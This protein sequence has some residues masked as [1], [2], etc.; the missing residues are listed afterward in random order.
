[1]HRFRVFRNDSAVNGPDTM[2]LDITAPRSARL[3]PGATGRF[4]GS[5]PSRSSR[6][7]AVPEV[8]RR[9]PPS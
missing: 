9:L 4:I 2:P 3:A 1:V 6:Y 8:V 7:K 5:A